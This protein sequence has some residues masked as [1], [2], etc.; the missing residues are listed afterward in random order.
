MIVDEHFPAK[1]K[2]PGVGAVA[3]FIQMKSSLRFG[4]IKEERAHRGPPLGGS[5][6]A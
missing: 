3:S 4:A 6:A 5:S 1:D 2:L